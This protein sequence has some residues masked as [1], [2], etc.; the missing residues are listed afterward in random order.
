MEERQRVAAVMVVVVVEEERKE[1]MERVCFCHPRPHTATETNERSSTTSSFNGNN[2][3]RRS[4]RVSQ[5]NQSCRWIIAIPEELWTGEII[6]YL[7]LKDLTRSRTI[8]KIFFQH[9]YETFLDKKTIRVPQDVPEIRKAISI[10]RHLLTQGGGGF[11]TSSRYTNEVPLVIKLSEG[12]HKIAP[13]CRGGFNTVMLDYNLHIIGEGPEKSIVEGGFSIKATVD[14][15]ILIKN[16]TLQGSKRQ[17]IYCHISSVI[18]VNVSITKTMNEGV[19]VWASRRNKMTNCQITNSKQC[20]L[21]VS[22]ALMTIDG[23]TSIHHNRGYGVMVNV[24]TTSQLVGIIQ[25]KSP[26]TLDQLDLNFDLA[27]LKESI[28]QVQA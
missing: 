18:L 21:H 13:W 25:I 4:T 3:P 2:Q 27:F 9:Y 19:F 10:G 16:M 7:N 6:P 11:T 20:G 12:H 17:G 26:L 8:E 28:V 24:H 14:D 15:D 5:Q 23:A 22:G 1:E